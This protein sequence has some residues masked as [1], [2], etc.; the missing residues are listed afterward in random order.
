MIEIAAQLKDGVLHPLTED[1]R[2]SIREYTPNQILHCKVSGVRKQRSYR[3]LK[4]YWSKCKVV[5]DNTEDPD[6][7]TKEMVDFQVRCA[8]R[9]YK[10]GHVKVV[11][12][13]VLF[14]LRSISY[15][16][17]PH[18]AACDYF[19]RADEVMADFLG[20]DKAELL[21]E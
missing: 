2:N 5:A 19:N 8:L 1:D 18:L 6:W 17:L 10:T 12:D 16:N 9:F 14:D 21:G 11:G 4:R 7:N 15:V 13:K 20:V 3:Q